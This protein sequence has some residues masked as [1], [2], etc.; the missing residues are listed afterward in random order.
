MRKAPEGSGWTWPLV[1]LSAPALKW[2]LA[3]ACRPSPPVCMSQNNAF[4][5]AIA[6]GVEITKPERFVEGIG[7]RLSE[8][9]GRLPPE[10]PP[11]VV[12]LAMVAAPVTVVVP[13]PVVE[14]AFVGLVVAVVAASS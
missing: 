3:H 1:R 10:P 4:P 2:Q 5:K 14:A 9:S 8:P 7:S 11:P 12:E 6:A 13:P